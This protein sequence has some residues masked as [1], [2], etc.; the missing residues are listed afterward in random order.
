MFVLQVDK[1]IIVVALVGI[2]TGVVRS[3]H[4]CNM[5]NVN[6]KHCLHCHAVDHNNFYRNA[7]D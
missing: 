7:S 2:Q 4:G 5:Y 1:V 3:N 6:R